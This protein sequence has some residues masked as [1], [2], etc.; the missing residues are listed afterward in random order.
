MTKSGRR[1]ARSYQE[2]KLIRSTIARFGL[3]TT[4]IKCVFQSYEHKCNATFLWFTVYFADCH[5]T[6]WEETFSA[7]DW[8]PILFVQLDRFVLM[9]LSGGVWDRDKSVTWHSADG[10][11]STVL[12]LT[13]STPLCENDDVKQGRETLS[14]V[15]PASSV[16]QNKNKQQVTISAA[17]Q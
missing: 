1:P 14:I 2:A 6:P 16:N 7:S 10:K 5:Y 3:K 12:C 8:K 9:S 11:E 13:E 4:K 17:N 15:L